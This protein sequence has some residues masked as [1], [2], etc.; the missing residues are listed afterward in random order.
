MFGHIYNGQQANLGARRFHAS[1]R[2]PGPTPPRAGHYQRL[3]F[4][5][6][7]PR[8]TG[9]FQFQGA[10][11]PLESGSYM[12]YGLFAIHPGATPA[13]YTFPV[14]VAS[15]PT[16]NVTT[17]KILGV[18]YAGSAPP[19]A[20]AGTYVAGDRIVLDPPSGGIQEWVCTVGG[21]PGTWVPVP[22]GASA[23][24]LGGGA[25]PT[26][27]NIGGAGPTAA[28]QSKWL[29]VVDATGATYFVPAWQ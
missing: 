29:K 18:Y 10:C 1:L 19:G 21:T 17:S 16:K 2:S 20:G 12:A 22:T 11:Y 5:F 7:F 28:A 13:P 9:T 3:W 6:Y 15:A 8:G 24:A 14:D 25:A 26:L 27:G 23:I 4:S